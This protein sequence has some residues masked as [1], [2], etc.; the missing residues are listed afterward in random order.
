MA[1]TLIYEQ[2]IN[3]SKTFA[4]VDLLLKSDGSMNVYFNDSYDEHVRWVVAKPAGTAKVGRKYKITYT[5][6]GTEVASPLT[7]YPGG[8]IHVPT[9]E[10]RDLSGTGYVR[11]YEEIP[12]TAPTTPGSFTS[13]ASSSTLKPGQSVTA[14]FGSS[15]DPDGNSISYIWGV[16]YNGG[17]FS[18]SAQNVYSNSFTTTIS[19]N[20][21][22]TSVQFRVKARDS[23]NADSGYRMSPVYTISQNSTPTVSLDT[24][25][26]RTLYENDTIGVSGTAQDAD[27][28]N[29]VSVKYQ[30]NS[31]TV[32][33]ISSQISNGSSFP[34]NRV[35][36][37]KQNKLYDG[38][39]TAI[40]PDLAPNTQ[41]VLKVWAEDDKGAKSSEVIRTFYVVPNRPATL[42]IEPFTATEGMID[43][44]SITIGGSVSDP[45]SN[46]VTV[47]YKIGSG[48][49]VDV[50][51]GNSG[52]FSFAVQLSQLS[53]GKNNITIQATDSYGA[54]SSK[55]VQVT[56][57]GSSVP[58]KTA[59][60]RYKLTPPNST[61]K[62]IVLWVQRE[63]GD[64]VLNAEISAGAN[65]SAENFVPMTKSSTAYVTDGL[66]ED[67]FTYEAAT[68]QEN[69]IL[70]LTM[71]RS[72]TSS[73]KGIKLISGVLS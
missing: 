34:F 73:D 12:N 4:Y 65:G 49:F 21:S 11:I 25:D 2:P 71:V 39:T 1:E 7:Y 58:L 63:V 29:I 32:Y 38:A 22:Y 20:S 53:A 23:N 51:S 33:P 66:E 37:F 6:L 61:A 44:D 17:S 64:L 10:E 41:H 40:T 14:S 72:A 28:N 35:L 70:K 30:I 16:A 9:N 59:I 15:S 36:T 69:I 5:V 24:T 62:G 52:S 19:T 13:P 54:L 57:A 31:G 46:S 47:K 26:S 27:V 68:A 43:S 18:D 3:E 8:Q 45:D 55:T 67:E 50:Y 48:S 60:M 56:K 42:T